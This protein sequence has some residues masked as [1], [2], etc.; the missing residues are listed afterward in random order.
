[1]SPAAAM[2]G[3]ALLAHPKRSNL[4]ANAARTTKLV[5]VTTEHLGEIDTLVSESDC[6]FYNANFLIEIEGV[7]PIPNQGGKGYV[8]NLLRWAV[9]IIPKD[10]FREAV[11]GGTSHLS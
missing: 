9:S 2:I 8:L 7:Q 6:L 11:A 5:L 10:A 1:M 3:S 4:V